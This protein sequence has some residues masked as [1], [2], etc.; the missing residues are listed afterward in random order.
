MLEKTSTHSEM[1]VGLLG[2]PGE[3]GQHLR[4][5]VHV[6][7]RNLWHLLPAVIVGAYQGF[8]SDAFTSAPAAALWA[9]VCWL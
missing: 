5:F 9:G 7:A 4:G 1:P 2:A 8:L 3:A 6:S